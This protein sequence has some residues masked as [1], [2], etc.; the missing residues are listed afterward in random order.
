[1]NWYCSSVICA[2]WNKWQFIFIQK[3]N[4][5]LPFLEPMSHDYLT[6][7]L[8]YNTAIYWH[9][10]SNS[11]SNVFIYLDV[12]ANIVYGIKGWHIVHSCCELKYH[13][14]LWNLHFLLAQEPV[15][16]YQ[17]EESVCCHSQSLGGQASGQW[18]SGLPCKCF[19]G[20]WKDPL[21]KSASE[22]RWQRNRL[23]VLKEFWRLH[24]L[25]QMQ[26]P[27]IFNLESTEAS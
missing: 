23:Y 16:L 7:E 14:L 19:G 2:I 18:R 4:I 25:H 22:S 6:L 8:Y 10:I 21:Y 13:H 27:S 12:L 3:A 20:D 1:M 26:F 24:V 17:A 9:I 5:L 11:T 15:L